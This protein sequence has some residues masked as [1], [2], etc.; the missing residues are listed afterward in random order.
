MSNL[1]KDNT[2]YAHFLGA[3][4][5]KKKSKNLRLLW[6]WVDGSRSH[7]DFFFFF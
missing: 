5:R 4:Q 6:K 2:S 3:L 7:S 1:Y